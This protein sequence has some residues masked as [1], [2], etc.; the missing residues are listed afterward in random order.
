MKEMELVVRDFP[1]AAIDIATDG[2]VFIASIKFRVAEEAVNRAQM[3]L[4]REMALKLAQEI[5]GRFNRGDDDACRLDWLDANPD[6]VEYF[7][8]EWYLSTGIY[9]HATLRE[10]IDAGM[11]QLARLRGEK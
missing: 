9:P 10:V 8:G 4:P 11:D 7:E 3:R 5:V 1:G 6:G 2:G